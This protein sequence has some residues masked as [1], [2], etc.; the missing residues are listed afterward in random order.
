MRAL[1]SFR[2]ARAV[3]LAVSGMS[4]DE[5]ASAVGYANRGTAWRTVQRALQDR[6]FHAV[7]EYREVELARLDALQSAC[8]DAALAGDLRAVE[9]VLRV[10]QQ[11]ARLL[12]LDEQM[13]TMGGNQG[14]F[15]ASNEQ[16][17]AV[18]S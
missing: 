4:Y 6:T 18:G 5:I 14:L 16:A 1:A 15:L 2:K 8:W 11:R 13:A 7:D 12:G 10:M 17:G 3:E 9:A